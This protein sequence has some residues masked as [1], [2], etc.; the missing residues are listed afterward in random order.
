[1]NSE[2]KLSSVHMDYDAFREAYKHAKENVPYEIGGFIMG[3]LGKWNNSY[4]L[5]I[6]KIVPVKSN[7][8]YVTVEF[9]S[10]D[11]GET[12]GAINKIKREDGYYIVGWYHSHPG[13]TCKP[14]RLDLKSHITYFREP[15]QVGLIIDP[16]NDDHCIFR[17]DS[18]FSYE[19]IPFYVWRRI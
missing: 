19:L 12:I 1:M 8:T 11:V 4:Y 17:A 18:V 9:L 13:Y 7:S 6:K 2:I 10:S 16:I 14:S 15:Y 3:Y 5:M